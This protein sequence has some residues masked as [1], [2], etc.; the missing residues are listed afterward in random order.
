MGVLKMGMPKSPWV[1]NGFNPKMLQ[2]P[3]WFGDTR[4]LGNL[5]E[6]AWLFAW[7]GR[8]NP[9]WWG[10]GSSR[11]CWDT[12]TDKGW[13]STPLLTAGWIVLDHGSADEILWETVDLL[14]VFEP[15]S[16]TPEKRRNLSKHVSGRKDM[17]RPP[18][19]HHLLQMSETIWEATQQTPATFSEWHG[20]D[21]T[22]RN[23]PAIIKWVLAFPVVVLDLAKSGRI[24]WLGHLP[25]DTF[26]TDHFHVI[27]TF[28]GVNV[29]CVRL[30]TCSLV[31]KFCKEITVWYTASNNTSA[32]VSVFSRD[33]FAKIERKSICLCMPGWIMKTH[34]DK[35][36][37]IR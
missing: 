11:S 8:Q 24:P 2:S 30:G 5:P 20:V 1:S 9:A 12:T 4:I 21:D 6:R 25:L 13:P 27:S 14:A 31:V 19:S 37:L 16:A 22:L 33:K 32:G 3:G 17:K 29:W 7:L 34:N 36:C 15:Y 23:G 28:E 10:I 18:K 35:V 26:G